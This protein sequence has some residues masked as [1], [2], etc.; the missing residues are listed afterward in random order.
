M[1]IEYTTGDVTKAREE[2]I[3][4]GC[5]DQGVMG[6]GV[7][8][9]IRAAYPEA[10][11][12]YRSLYEGPG[13]KLGS[14]YV[15][16]SR[17]KLIGNAITQE[18]FGTDRRHVDYHAVIE[19]GVRLNEYARLHGIKRVALPRIGAGL[20]GGDWSILSKLIENTAKD[21]QPV[22]YDF[23]PAAA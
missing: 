6:G 18:F 2:M 4:H 7:A 11:T 3:V 13:L 16:S 22:V 14:L 8:L 17:G 12:H 1:L 5:N 9:A 10:Y 23:V 21:Y 15:C 19:V 20:A